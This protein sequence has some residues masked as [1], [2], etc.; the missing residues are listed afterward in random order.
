MVQ[1]HLMSD[2]HINLCSNLHSINELIGP[3]HDTK[4]KILVLA[5]DIG[6]PT[7]KKY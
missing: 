7:N 6:N 5:G 3:T 1:I 2:L 4:N